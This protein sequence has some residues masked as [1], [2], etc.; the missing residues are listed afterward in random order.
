MVESDSGIY[1]NQTKKLYDNQKMYEI[2]QWKL[3]RFLFEDRI[4]NGI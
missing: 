1:K 3:H 2:R 4:N